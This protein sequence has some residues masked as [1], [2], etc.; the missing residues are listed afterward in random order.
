MK[1]NKY[2][3]IL[4]GVVVLV[5]VFSWFIWGNSQSNN[6]FSNNNDNKVEQTSETT[7]KKDDT[8]TTETENVKKSD[9]IEKEPSQ[10]HLWTAE[11]AQA[12]QS[13]ISEWQVEMNQFYTS[14]T[15]DSPL[16][17]YGYLTPKISTVESD[18][19]TPALNDSPINVE[20][21]DTGDKPGVYN[22]VAVYSDYE[23]SYPDVK[24]LYYFVIKDGQSMVLH[25]SQNQGN[26]NNWLY[27]TETEN[28][29][30]KNGFKTIVGQ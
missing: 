11:K 24:H 30:L 14:Y 18:S 7:D 16:N 15:P 29:D 28:I 27:F 3:P 19:M 5:S 2:L 6:K 22:L 20:W 8:K 23:Q 4:F 12:L 9:Q 26:E 17:Y 21:S 25:T 1:K 10:N 13:F